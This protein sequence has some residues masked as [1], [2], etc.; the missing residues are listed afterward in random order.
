MFQNEPQLTKRLA[1][2]ASL[3]VMKQEEIMHVVGAA[4]L[5]WWGR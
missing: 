1:T 2:V 4:V 3:K 5:I